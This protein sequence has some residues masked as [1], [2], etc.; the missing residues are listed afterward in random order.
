MFVGDGSDRWDI[1]YTMFRIADSFDIDRTCVLVDG[2]V[3]FGRVIAHYPLDLDFELLQI[4]AE[5]VE[6][7]TI[8]FTADALESL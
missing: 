7:A 6:T 8:H 4:D 5:L 2:L 3:E 1:W